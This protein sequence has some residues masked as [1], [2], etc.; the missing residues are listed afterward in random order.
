[1]SS[2]LPEDHEFHR[3][4]RLAAEKKLARLERRRVTRQTVKDAWRLKDEVAQHVAQIEDDRAHSLRPTHQIPNN[5]KCVHIPEKREFYKVVACT[6]ET[7]VSVYDGKTEYVLGREV[8]GRGHGT[9]EIDGCS[10]EMGGG[11]VALFFLLKLTTNER[12]DKDEMK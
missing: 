5:W 12:E 9:D 1:M 6:D 2:R 11:G 7:F 4:N 3:Y 10:E 8:R